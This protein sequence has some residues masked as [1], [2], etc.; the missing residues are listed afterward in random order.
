MTLDSF[1]QRHHGRA[2]FATMTPDD[3]AALGAVHDDLRAAGY[4][5]AGIRALSGIPT[6]PTARP[7]RIAMRCVHELVKERQTQ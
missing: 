2:V 6:P 3:R 7:Q 5:E 4:D 1:S